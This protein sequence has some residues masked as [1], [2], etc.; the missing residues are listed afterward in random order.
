[1]S[2]TNHLDSRAA[3]VDRI[4]YR[5]RLRRRLRRPNTVCAHNTPSPSVV[6][7]PHPADGSTKIRPT[8]VSAEQQESKAL[9]IHQIQLIETEAPAHIMSRSDAGN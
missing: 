4:A 1:M 8:C 5:W 7:G 3:R 9:E 2:W 6:P